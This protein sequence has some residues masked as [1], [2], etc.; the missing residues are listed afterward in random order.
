MIETKLHVPPL[1][2]GAVARPRLRARLA[3]GLQPGVKL[4]LLSAPAGYGKTTAILDFRRADPCDAPRLAWLSLDPDDDDPVRFVTYIAAALHRADE[5]VGGDVLAALAVSPPPALRPLLAELVNGVAARPDPLFLVLD[6]YHVLGDPAIHDLVATLLGHQP[7][8]LRLVLL[9]RADPPL[10]LAELRARGQLVELRQADLRFD[11]AEA[12]AFLAGTMGLDVPPEAAAAL[13]AR[14]EGW[15]AGLQLAAL[16]LRDAGDVMRAAEAFTGTHR[17]VLD[18]LLP[19]VLDRQ[20]PHVQAFLLATSILERLCAPLCEAVLGAAGFEEVRGRPRDS[21]SLGAGASELLAYLDRANLFLVPLDDERRWYRYHGLFRDL[22][23]RRLAKLHPDRVPVLHRRASAWH[24]AAGDVGEAI[25]HAL[26]AGDGARAAALVEATAEPVLARSQVSTLLRWL[27]ALPADAVRRRASLSLYYAWALFLAGRPLEEIAQRLSDAEAAPD[28]DTRQA[29]TLQAMLAIFQ[30]KAPKAVAL[31]HHALDTLPDDHFLRGVAAWNLA[32][33]HFMAGDLDAAGEA[34][35]QAIALGLAAGNVLIA[36][37]SLCHLAELR[38]VQGRL[39][40]SQRLYRRALALSTDGA[41]RRM[42][43]AGVALVGL[44]EVL[45]EMDDL[46]AAEAYLREGVGLA[47][48]WGP[49]GAL[50]GYV[51]LARV[52][53]ARGDAGG[54]RRF[55]DRARSLAARFDA[56]ELDDV[57]VDAF[58]A[59]LSVLQGRDDPARLVEAGRWAARVG[60][61]EAP[62]HGLAIGTGYLTSL[63]RLVYAR[64]L[65]RRGRPAEA[66]DQGHDIGF[67]FFPVDVLVVHAQALDALGREAAAL[68]ALDRALALAAAEGHARAFLDEGPPVA[69]LLAGYVARAAQQAGP[70]SPA[71]EHA[72]RLLARAGHPGAPPPPVEPLTAR[73][74]EVLAYLPGP[75]TTPEIADALGIAPSTVRTHVKRIYGKL[76]AHGR[77]EAVAQAEALGLLE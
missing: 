71:G 66:W 37:V 18:Y 24:E 25:D 29:A 11:D 7:A 35:K 72:A 36:A 38:M 75:L 74:L 69:R 41:G 52:R 46:D 67:D 43:I 42:P 1:R 77:A 27:E 9:T 50:D 8:N 28:A 61:R 30:G 39:R 23:R 40:E 53:L 59:H 70:P 45:R 62:R 56:S 5:A 3:T 2:P 16:S 57:M 49:I 47:R 19:Q 44:G 76:D 31:A 58:E 14:T 32:L 34:L 64:F 51:S 21:E 33:V 54:A 48:D 26:A 20:P 63:E 73:E 60:A 65:L 55:I 17:Y 22:L 12:A 15:P 68:D 13:A 6:D 10:P 4:V